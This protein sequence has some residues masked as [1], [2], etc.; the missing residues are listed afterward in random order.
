MNRDYRF[1]QEHGP[2]CACCATGHLVTQFRKESFEHETEDGPV[3][4]EADRVPINVCDTCGS[5]FVTALTAKVRH[6]YV[7]RMLGLITPDEIRE[8]RER[9]GLT[10]TEFARITKFGESSISRWERGRLL[11][12]A[13]NSTYLKILQ[14][15]PQ[16]VQWLVKASADLAHNTVAEPDPTARRCRFPSLPQE[17]ITNLAAKAHRF[18]LV[19]SF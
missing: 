15:D 2:N 10:K 5:V 4:V 14:H 16:T 11:P 17:F 12:N 19:A 9:H 1:S 3:M 6:E 13:S 18:A 7:C 8:I